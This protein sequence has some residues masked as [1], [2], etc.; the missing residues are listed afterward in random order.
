MK[1]DHFNQ[2]LAT[3]AGTNFSN[4]EERERGAKRFAFERMFEKLK[5]IFKSS[6]EE[7]AK[8]VCVQDGITLLKNNLN[9]EFKV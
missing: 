9:L 4:F 5:N 8:Y 3:G 2:I 6:V 7:F 1:D